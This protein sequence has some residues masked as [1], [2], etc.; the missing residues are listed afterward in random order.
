MQPFE[1][2]LTFEA[3]KF[4]EAR[5]FADRI[6]AGLSV[7]QLDLFAIAVLLTVTRL[8]APT[9]HELTC[10]EQVARQLRETM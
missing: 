9:E 7:E 8:D 2:V 6:W 10:A 5:R 3:E 4:E 1:F